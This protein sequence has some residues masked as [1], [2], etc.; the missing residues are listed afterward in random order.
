MNHVTSVGLD[1]HARSITA[2]SFNPLTGEVEQELHPCLRGMDEE[3]EGCFIY[4]G[5]PMITRPLSLY[6]S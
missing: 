6:F 1:V 2:A 5:K 3:P 4:D